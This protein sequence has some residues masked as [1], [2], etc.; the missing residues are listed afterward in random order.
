M[1]FKNI[2]DKLELEFIVPYLTYRKNLKRGNEVGF[3][4]EHPKNKDGSLVSDVEL[5]NL[6]KM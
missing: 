6:V 4:Y 1:E 2:K 5:E 3:V